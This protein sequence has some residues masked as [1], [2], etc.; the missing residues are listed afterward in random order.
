MKKISAILFTVIMMATSNATAQNNY[1]ALNHVAIFVVD[2]AKS[3]HFYK[4]IIGLPEIPEPFLDGKH[5]WLK[6]GEHSQLH[7]IA[8]ATSIT[9]HDRRTHICFSVA[10]L[11]SMV[12][13]LDK[14]KI[15]FTNATGVPQTITV[16]PDGV[17][18]IY[19]KDPDGFWVEINNDR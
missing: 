16:R 5:T 3:T 4:N 14:N 17:K 9:I 8:G 2:L 7:L 10:S 19:C 13:V 6:T 11:D 12:K 15:P 18:Q 1:P